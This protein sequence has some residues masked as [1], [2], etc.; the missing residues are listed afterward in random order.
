MQS[1]LKYKRENKI[2][3]KTIDYSVRNNKYLE[4]NKQSFR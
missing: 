1:L 4:I 3:D 2:D